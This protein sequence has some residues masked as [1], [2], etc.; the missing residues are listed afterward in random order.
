MSSPRGNV[1]L[2]LSGERGSPSSSSKCQI[3]SRQQTRC[4]RPLS[5]GPSIRDVCVCVCVCV[6]ACVR[7][8][9]CVFFSSQLF[10]YQAS[11]VR[12]YLRLFSLALCI[13][14][15]FFISALGSS[16]FILSLPS[17]L[18]VFLPLWLFCYLQTIGMFIRRC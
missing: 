8:C 15:S 14:T 4:S 1:R 3:R 13:R 17:L 2:M 12:F 6:C 11:S 9:V 16:Y 18:L 10:Y 7:L 5:V